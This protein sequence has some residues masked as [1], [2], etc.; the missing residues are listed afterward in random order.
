MKNVTIRVTC[1]VLHKLDWS[2]S[3]TLGH[4]ESSETGDH[5]HGE[6]IETL[7]RLCHH[8]RNAC[9]KQ[10]RHSERMADAEKP[11][12]AEEPAPAA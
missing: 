2:N 4:A 3:T 1:E 7:E 12:A 11:E 6:A 8:V 9:A 5:T 10:V